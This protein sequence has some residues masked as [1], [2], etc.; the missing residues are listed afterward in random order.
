MDYKELYTLYGVVEEAVDFAF[1]G[2]YVLNMYDYL[3]SSK[4]TK[5]D[6]EEFINSVT[7]QHINLLVLDL[8]SYLEGGADNDHKQLREGYGHLGKPEA[9]KIKN[10]LYK[11][12][13]D[14][15]QYEKEKRPG[16]KRKRTK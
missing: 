10:Y 16:R 14:S 13:E 1:Q 5:R 9:R 12:L 3:K 6:T 7:A 11:I 15:W 4:A 8:E 2:K